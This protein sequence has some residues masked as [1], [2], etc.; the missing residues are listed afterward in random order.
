MKAAL[1]LLSLFLL[2]IAPRA[3]SAQAT[4]EVSTGVGRALTDD[5]FC[6]N[7]NV[8]STPWGDERT[9][10]QVRQLGYDVLRIP[11]GTVANYWD[12]ALGWADAPRYADVPPRTVTTADFQ[13]ELA[14]TNTRPLIGLNMLTSDLETQ[15]DALRQARAD[16]MDTGLIEL[17]NELDFPFAEE[18][19]KYPTAAD[20]GNAAAEW[21]TAISAEF[22]ESRFSVIAASQNSST[23][24]ARQ[25]GWNEAVMPIVQSLNP[26]AVLHIYAGVPLPAGA[27][28]SF[29]N[30]TDVLSGPFARWEMVKRFDLPEIPASM[31][32][33]VTEYNSFENAGSVR[34]GGTWA[35]ALFTSTFS[36]LLLEEPRI[37]IACVH[38]LTGNAQWS[39]FY[40]EE[41]PA[42][43]GQFSVSAQGYALRL[44]G[45]ALGE[46]VQAVPLRFTPTPSA[47]N[48][49]GEAFDT[50]VGWQ[51]TTANGG[52]RALLA[53][54]GGAAVA[55]N[56]GGLAM[57]NSRFEML[58][59]NPLTLVTSEAQLTRQAGTMGGEL[60]MPPYSLAVI[61]QD[62][63]TA[64]TLQLEGR[65]APP[66]AQHTVDVQ[67]E[68]RD[69]EGS[70]VVAG[71][72]STT[73]SG[74]LNLPPAA[75]G[76]YTLWVKGSHTL[77]HAQPV[78]LA[79]AANMIGTGLLRE[80]DSNNDNVVNISDFSLL[81]AAF[82]TAFGAELFDGRADFNG[83]RIVNI[84][85]FSLLAGN[86]GQ[87]GPA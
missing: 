41:V 4:I 37:E 75:P 80:G 43:A 28:L 42:G 55:F 2:S 73:E 9:N 52:K 79:P 56:T 25:A 38:V 8:L 29:A 19:A 62:A 30:L 49:R 85:D 84:S 40:Y 74:L 32:V 36:L 86:F 63:V 39:A 68:L 27:A 77:A 21:I 82:G 34:V 1:V 60:T 7:V 65:P 16:G 53:N 44:F 26:A 70:I 69:G 71:A 6:T 67:Y 58:S 78:S 15:L 20:Y 83:D 72:S 50:L 64:L 22:P 61:E 13:A 10:T 47:I 11:G 54:L 87:A 12:W 33:W 17:G 76:G 18:V 5:Y 23:P 57:P 66:T 35:G 48:S 51:F 24:V 14:A 45:R 31:P 3:I 81:A 46:A 59:G